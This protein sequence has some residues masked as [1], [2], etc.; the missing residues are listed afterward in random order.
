MRSGVNSL[1][2]RDHLQNTVISLAAD[3][4]ILLLIGPS[5]GATMY[6]LGEGTRPCPFAVTA[7]EHGRVTEPG[8]LSLNLEM[9]PKGRPQ[10]NK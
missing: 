8:R 5:K 9:V 7:N 2:L 10:K 1:T 3:N 4:V 6:H